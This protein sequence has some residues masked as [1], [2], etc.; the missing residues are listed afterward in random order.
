MTLA[1]LPKECFSGSLSHHLADPTNPRWQ[2]WI[3]F[4]SQRVKGLAL[5]LRVQDLDA[6]EFS[7]DKYNFRTKYLDAS[8]GS[9]VSEATVTR[10]STWEVQCHEYSLY[11][12]QKR[13]LGF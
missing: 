6:E 4:L 7:V 2:I 1:F 11:Y 9:Y 5:P 12:G 13:R 10:S 3:M 8:K